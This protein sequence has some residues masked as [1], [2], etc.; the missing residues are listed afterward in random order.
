MAPLNRTGE[1]VSRQQ[2]LTGLLF[3]PQSSSTNSSPARSAENT[4]AESVAKPKPVEP[5]NLLGSEK[6]NLRTNPRKNQFFK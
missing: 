4:F 3:S 2:R 6:I 5:Q 1:A